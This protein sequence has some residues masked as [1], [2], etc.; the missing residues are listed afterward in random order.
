MILVRS[1]FQ[2]FSAEANFSS[3]SFRAASSAS[4]L[5]CSRRRIL[6]HFTILCHASKTILH[7]LPRHL[8]IT[9]LTIC[10][11]LDSLSCLTFSAMA[12]CSFSFFLSSLIFS[13]RKVSSTLFSALDTA[14]SFSC[15]AFASAAAICF[16]CS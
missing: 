12:T 9:V 3:A 6:F 16:L 2:A 1:E 10:I 15:K 8:A 4:F 11:L 14:N 5:A 13:K 7:F